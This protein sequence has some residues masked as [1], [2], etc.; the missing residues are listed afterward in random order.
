MMVSNGHFAAFAAVTFL[1]VVVPGPSVLFDC[2][3]A[4]RAADRR[5]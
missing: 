2:R 4:G 3:Q 1:M 5:R